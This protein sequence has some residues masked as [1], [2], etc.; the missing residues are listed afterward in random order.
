LTMA[1]WRKGGRDSTWPIINRMILWVLLMTVF[2]IRILLETET[3]ASFKSMVILL[4]ARI[5]G[6]SPNI[7]LSIFSHLRRSIAYWTRDLFTISLGEQSAEK[8]LSNG[9]RILQI[10]V[11]FFLVNMRKT[12]VFCFNAVWLWS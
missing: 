1:M 9:T 4:L 2:S 6:M 10:I 11:F 7:W 3:Q 12:F 8:K 5:T